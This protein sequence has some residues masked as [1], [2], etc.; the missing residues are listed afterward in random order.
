MDTYLNN[1][2]AI[3]RLKR[4]YK[5]HNNIVIGFDFDDTIFPY[6]DVITED[7]PELLRRCKK[8][9]LTL[10]IWST[11]SRP[12]DIKYKVYIA[13]KMGIKPDYVNE[14]P[15]YNSTTKPYFNLL[16]DDRSGLASSYEILKTTLDELNL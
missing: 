5:E 1:R 2:N 10:C 11:C 14:S 7:V 15:L 13:D 9:G 16:L 12:N 8:A 6:H 4:E 3:E